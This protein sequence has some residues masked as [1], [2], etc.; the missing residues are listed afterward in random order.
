MIKCAGHQVLHLRNYILKAVFHCKRIVACRSIFFCDN[1][2]SSTPVLMEQRN[3][4][5]FATIRL[6]WKTG[7]CQD[8]SI[9]IRIAIL[10]KIYFYS[11]RPANLPCGRKLECAEKTHDF[12]QSVDIL[13]SHESIEEPRQRIEPTTQR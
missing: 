7:F 10:L 6:Q 2:I 11:N 1:I 4:V 9:F 8:Y 3:T 13:F 12:C 5:C